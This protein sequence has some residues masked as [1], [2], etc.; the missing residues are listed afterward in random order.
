[1]VEQR[2]R[3]QQRDRRRYGGA[4]VIHAGQN[5]EEDGNGDEVTHYRYGAI[6]IPST[7]NNAVTGV[8]RIAAL[9]LTLENAAGAVFAA[10]SRTRSVCVTQ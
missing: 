10:R 4:I 8:A 9:L 6:I 2:Q 7:P 5:C 1:M 3:R